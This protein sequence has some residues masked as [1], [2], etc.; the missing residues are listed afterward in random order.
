MSP[1]EGRGSGHG[2]QGIDRSP[3]TPGGCQAAGGGDRLGAC[4]FLELQL[5]TG[6]STEITSHACDARNS[7]C[8]ELSLPSA[9]SQENSFSSW[10]PRLSSI[11]HPRKKLGDHL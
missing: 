9:S 8:L 6:I 10:A 1:E 5:Q 3:S 11:R 4:S 2:L 7:I